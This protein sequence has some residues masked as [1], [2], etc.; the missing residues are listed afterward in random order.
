MDLPR[1]SLTKLGQRERD[2][3]CLAKAPLLLLALPS[4]HETSSV[5]PQSSY[6]YSSGTYRSL[7]AMMYPYEDR[8]LPSIRVL[9]TRTTIFSYPDGRIEVELT[10]SRSYMDD[11]WISTS[12]Y[13]SH[14]VP[15]LAPFPPR[16]LVP[17]QSHQTEITL[18]QDHSASLLK[19]TVITSQ[20]R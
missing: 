12:L 4:L 5:H 8:I 6:N 7:M 3:F 17:W 16:G 9:A 19:F 15:L 10:L 2:A 13:S 14:L 20:S 1:I 18:P 11:L